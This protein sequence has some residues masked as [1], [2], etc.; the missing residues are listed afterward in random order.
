MPVRTS[1]IQGTPNWVDL[2]A[3]DQDAAKAFYSGLFGWTYDDQPMP[4]GQVYSMAML[5]EHA[6]AALAPQP[7]EMAA[8]WREDASLAA[9]WVDKARDHVGT[10]PPKVKKPKKR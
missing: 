2:Q 7:P 5:G 1:Y 9:S 3:P 6:V 8:A 4:E 10:L